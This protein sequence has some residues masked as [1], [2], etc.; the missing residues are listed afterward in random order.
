[1]LRQLKTP[2]FAA[3]LLMLALASSASAQQPV[4]VPSPPTTP[5]TPTKGTTGTTTS[6][7]TGG[8]GL[9]GL[10]LGNILGFS[11]TTPAQDAQFLATAMLEVQVI[12]QLVTLSAEE[13]QILLFFFYEYE[14]LSAIQS[15]LFGGTATTPGG[16]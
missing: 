16:P 8:T 14:Q 12:A 9:G 15:L 5:T 3:G 13:E 2:W 11:L 1:M 6:T 4:Q 7:G 10:G